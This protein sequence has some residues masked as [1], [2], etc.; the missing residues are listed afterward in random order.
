MNSNK[1]VNLTSI[2]LG[3]LALIIIGTLG[4]L[5]SNFE[6]AATKN[7]FFKN[8]N[9]Y[10]YVSEI[11]KSHVRSKYPDSLRN[12]P[13]N[14][15][16]SESVLNYIITPSTV[17]TIAVPVLQRRDKV[18]DRPTD[19]V[20]DDL[21]LN[22]QKYKKQVTQSISSF[23]L[24]EP[25]TTSVTNVINSAP[26]SITLVD[27]SKNPNSILV[28]I[29]RFRIFIDNSKMLTQAAWFVLAASIIVLLLFNLRTM[30]A[31]FNSL[32]WI[33]GV[34][35]ILL[36]LA[37]FLTPSAFNS[38]GPQSTNQISGGLQDSL[39]QNIVTYLCD[40]IRNISY[41]YL[42]IT[43]VVFLISRFVP[44]SPAEAWI[45]QHIFAV[46]PKKKKA[47][48]TRSALAKNA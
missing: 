11:I 28:A 16:I 10:Y 32:S 37:S 9:T 15:A 26:N 19:I 17:E 47:P 6:N 41:W 43:A 36:L 44:F 42:A 22:T 4:V 46:K 5:S 35:G 13:I 33:F 2:I 31:L 12:N 7:Q 27:T 30:K 14:L 38:F 20:N 25:V 1:I 18:K 48:A 34:S 8:S 21:V 40:L 3:S 24:P 29:T 23:N 45:N 39:F